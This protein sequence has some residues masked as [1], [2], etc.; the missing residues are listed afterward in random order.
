M[1]RSGW[2]TGITILQLIL[3]LSV[4]AV[5][6]YLLW[7]IRTPQIRNGDD[8]ANAIYGLKIAAGM[9]FP[10]ALMY[11]GGA[12]GMWKRKLWGWWVSLVINA[13]CALVFAYSMFDDG[14]RNIDYEL[15]G[16]T[17]AFITSFALLLVGPVRKFYWPRGESLPGSA[18]PLIEKS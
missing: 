10:P 14:I 12:Y 3:G 9:L 17:L 5:A 13:G 4:L 7:L 8:A 1:R 16:F 18:E 2:V 6:G 11:L 15:L